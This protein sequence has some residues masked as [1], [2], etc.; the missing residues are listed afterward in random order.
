[1]SERFRVSKSED[2]N[3]IF[4][5]YSESRISED[6]DRAT[7][8]LLPTNNASLRKTAGQGIFRHR[9]LRL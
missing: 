6:E 7:E 8:K 1:M 9:N 3:S 4:G 2:P 5:K